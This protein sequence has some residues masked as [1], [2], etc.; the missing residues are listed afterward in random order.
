MG[1]ALGS[2]RPRVSRSRIANGHDAV[3]NRGSTFCMCGH[4]VGGTS[5]LFGASG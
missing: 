2:G 5:C 4:Q 1:V 3:L